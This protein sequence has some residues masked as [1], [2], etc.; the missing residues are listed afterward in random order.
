MKA[1]RSA[2]EN[3][4]VPGLETQ[5][6][7]VRSHVRSAF[8]NYSDDPERYADA[9]NDQPVRSLPF[10]H[11]AADGIRQPRNHF[12]AGSHGLD[13]CLIEHEAVEHCAGQ[14]SL[15]ARRHILRILGQNLPRLRSDPVRS[16]QQGRVP[17]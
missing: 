10:R 2:T 8:V 7:G 15:A 14:T 9:L 5:G 11:D 3:H 6:G 13:A 4:G 12:E 16:R 1:L 17:L